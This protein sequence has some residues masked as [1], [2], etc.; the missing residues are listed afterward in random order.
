MILM[1]IAAVL[2]LL[3]ARKPAENPSS[4]KG[5]PASSSF[6]PG[7]DTAAWKSQHIGT[8]TVELPPPLNCT[9]CVSD[10]GMTGVVSSLGDDKAFNARINEQDDWLFM[11]TAIPEQKLPLKQREWSVLAGDFFPTI[12]RLS[13]GSTGMI[14]D[15]ATGKEFIFKR[16]ADVRID[17]QGAKVYDTTLTSQTPVKGRRAVFHRGGKIYSVIFEWTSPRF[18]GVFDHIVQTFHIGS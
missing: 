13:V 2:V 17:G 1:L 8:Y 14:L 18:D 9:E 15:G 11:V 6:S 16:V 10:Q 5:A 4:A 3:G 12:E 7:A